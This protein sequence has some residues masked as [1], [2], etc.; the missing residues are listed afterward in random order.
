MSKPVTI[1]ALHGTQWASMG[2]H[3]TPLQSMAVYGGR[4]QSTKALLQ[5]GY[6]LIPYYRKALD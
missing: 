4:W 2:A 5:G 3:G 1:I 6:S